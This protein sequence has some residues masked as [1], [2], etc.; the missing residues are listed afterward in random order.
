MIERISGKIIEKSPTFCVLDCHGLGIGLQISLN[1]FQYLERTIDVETVHLH[2]YLHVRED[3]LKL[4]GFASVA[5]KQL[6]QLLISISGVGPKLAI[7]ILSGS[8]TDDLRAAITNE[9]VGRLTRIP[10]VGKKTAQR[11][12]LELKEKINKQSAVEKIAALIPGAPQQYQKV[13]EAMLALME[14]GYKQQNAR[15]AVEKILKQGADNL[16][17]EELVVSALKEL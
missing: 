16:S 12:I 4:Y 11:V 13:N 15:Q 5:E 2:S 8:S 7:S 17:L 1:T 9:D 14:L 10:G 6:F 3:A